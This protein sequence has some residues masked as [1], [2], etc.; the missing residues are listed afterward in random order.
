MLP[1]EPHYLSTS[2]SWGG[3]VNTPLKANYSYTAGFKYEEFLYFATYS[4]PAYLL[5]FDLANLTLDAALLELPYPAENIVSSTV[6]N[7][8][9]YLGCDSANASVVA[10]VDLTTFSNPYL[11]LNDSTPGRLSGGIIYNN[12]ILFGISTFEIGLSFNLQDYSSSQYFVSLTDTQVLVS[13][14]NYFYFVNSVGGIA[15]FDLNTSLSDGY[16]FNADSNVTCGVVAGSYA[17]FGTLNGSIYR[18]HIPNDCPNAFGGVLYH[19]TSRTVYSK[20]GTCGSCST[21]SGVITCIDGVVGGDTGYPYD[22]CIVYPKCCNS[23]FGLLEVGKEMQ[24]FEQP[25][26][27]CG[28]TCVNGTITCAG[29]D[30]VLEG[31]VTWKYSNCVQIFS[32]TC[33]CG[34]YSMVHNETKHLYLYSNGSCNT[35]CIGGNLTCLNGQIYG[36]TSYTQPSCNVSNCPCNNVIGGILLD[37][38]SRVLYSTNK[39]SCSSTCAASSTTVTCNNGQALYSVPGNFTRLNCSECGVEPISL[40][41]ATNATLTLTSGVIQMFFPAASNV[42]V[43]FSEA[44]PSNGMCSIVFKRF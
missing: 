9:A 5:K 29:P 1:S 11:L 27:S 10:V 24:V 31:N 7:G 34:Q 44:T 13:R 32:A 36:N 17:Y 28:S 8:V 14:D 16:S 43:I 38:E 6:Y 33:P 15:K 12:Q 30:G 3:F 23:S 41:N 37:K 22:S 35:G 39:S 25:S 20:T 42:S 40:Q 26:A 21:Y 2:T 4:T 19:N 18:V